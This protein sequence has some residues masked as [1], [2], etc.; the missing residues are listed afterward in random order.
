V[1]EQNFELTDVGVV[2][3]AAWSIES[4]DPFGC[5]ELVQLAFSSTADLNP[6]RYLT[7]YAE[8]FDRER[9]ILW[10]ITAADDRFMKALILS[11]RLVADKVREYLPKWQQQPRNK[12]IRRLEHTLYR[13]L[14]R[15][16]GRTTPNGLWAGVG[17]FHCSERSDCVET[18]AEYA[19]APD[20]R[21]F[22]SI[23]RALG[24]R[25]IYRQNSYWQVNPTLNRLDD[26]W[27]FWVRN[28]TDDAGW[29]QIAASESI[30]LCL[31]TM[32]TLPPLLGG[33]IVT[34]IDRMSPPAASD[35]LD[36]LIDV[37]A[38]VGGLDLPS[39]FDT[40]WDGLV[41]SGEKLLGTDRDLWE[42]TIDRLYSLCGELNSH[43]DE[44][45]AVDLAVYLDEAR[46]AIIELVV[47]LAIPV[48]EIDLPDTIL[49][50][51]LLLPWQITLD[52]H[53]FDRL[54]TTIGTYN[55]DWLDRTSPSMQFRRK[56]RTDLQSQLA[57][58][59][60][61]SSSEFTSQIK[62]DWDDISSMM[63][64]DPATIDRLQNW[65]ELL[66]QSTENVYL[67]TEVNPVHDLISTAPLGCFYFTPVGDWQLIIR[68]IDDD[69]ARAFVRFGKLLDNKAKLSD[70][71]QQALVKIESKHYLKLVELLVPFE[72]NPN[73]LARC[74]FLNQNIDLWGANP[75][76]LSLRLASIGIDRHSQAPVLLIPSLP[77]PI[78]I[79]FC[80]SA[81]I[82]AIDPIANLM[83]HTGFQERPNYFQSIDLLANPNSDRPIYTPRIKLESEEIIRPRRTVL[84]RESIQK[85]IDSSPPERYQIW[86]QMAR[87]LGWSKLL[88]LQVDRQPS[89]LIKSSSPLSLEAA[90]KSFKLDTQSVIVE[91][92][93]DL[94]WLTDRAGKHY[95]TEFAMPFQRSQHGWSK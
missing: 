57:E 90:F 31:Q 41:A 45:D 36:A 63:M 5:Q 13:Y 51:D 16:V 6:H 23:L 38:I 25:S 34:Q 68:G 33:E 76:S 4:L 49:H 74:Q 18:A 10:E 44:I 47:E 21:P 66:N 17:L 56:Q 8:I 55:R 14:A 3:G 78:A 93:I 15:A 95:F 48:T 42:L 29:C 2:R 52:R 24:T 43:L 58:G 20:L 28:A 65:A 19:F 67:K 37:G 71:M 82:G 26:A 94:P 9:E 75:D 80:C 35:W 85:I 88:N 61:L 46:E 87:D 7:L 22:Q 50:C 72:S 89:L 69:P 27:Q 59:I 84:D 62:T 86:Q 91:E 92:I 32:L 81:N 39:R 77:N 70:W 11:N 79:F 40:V 54:A 30:D 83:L 60:E 64:T 12:T 53:K 73:V 1:I